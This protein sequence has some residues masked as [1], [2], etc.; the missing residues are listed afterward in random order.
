MGGKMM[1][2]RVFPVCRL[3][4]VSGFA[5]AIALTPTIALFAGPSPTIDT[6]MTACPPGEEADS[7]TLTCV[8]HLVPRG[9]LAPGPSE[10]EREQDV[11]DTPGFTSPNA[12]GTTVP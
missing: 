1:A 2:I 5:A 6:T 3:T 9:F 4:V 12:G 8:P 7:F 11:L 10:Q